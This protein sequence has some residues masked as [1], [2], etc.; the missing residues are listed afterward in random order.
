MGFEVGGYVAVG[1]GFNHSIFLAAFAHPFSPFAFAV[2]DALFVG[3]VNVADVGLSAEFSSFFKGEFFGS[4]NS[5]GADRC[6]RFG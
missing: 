6:G 2:L 5:S 4:A 1:L 3:G